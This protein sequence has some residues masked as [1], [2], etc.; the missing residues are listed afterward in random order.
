MP[1]LVKLVLKRVIFSIFVLLGVTFVTFLI[2]HVIVPNPVRAWVG[3]HSNPDVVRS[4]TERYHLNDPLWE[5]YVYYMYNLVRGDWG[6]SPTTG[7]SVL[8]ELQAFFPATLELVLA[9]I[10]LSFVIGVPLGAIAAVR[11]NR[12]MDVGITEFYLIGLSSPPFVAALLLQFAFSYY[13]QIFPSVGEISPTISAPTTITGMFVVDSLLTGNLPAFLSSLQHIVLP[14]LALTF[15]TFG[16]FTRLTRSSMLD[17][18]NKDYIR[19]AT[20]K[21]LNSYYVNV[22]HG[23]RTALIPSVTLLAFIVG[24]L[25]GGVVVIEYAFGW[26]GLGSYTIN[27]IATVNFPDIIG[28]TTVFAIGVVVSNLA[29]DVLYAFL[30]PR[31][32]I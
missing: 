23:L 28:V 6:I 25:L 19:A 20:A 26:P 21:G 22:R 5:Q 18:L 8:S 4:Y 14:T 29:A 7:R 30:D 17:V 13:F 32:R 15:L 1:K 12:K 16:L 24:Q 11:N 27:A 9:S 3:L 10:I 31:I 2:A